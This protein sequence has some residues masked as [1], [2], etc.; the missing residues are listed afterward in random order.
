MHYFFKTPPRPVGDDMCDFCESSV[1]SMQAFLPDNVTWVSYNTKYRVTQFQEVL[2]IQNVSTERINLL[3]LKGFKPIL[4]FQCLPMAKE[5]CGLP[6]C[7]RL[8]HF[9]LS[10]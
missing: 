10:R 9:S 1:T 6:R 5:N 3:R 4:N 8:L 2:M 7:K